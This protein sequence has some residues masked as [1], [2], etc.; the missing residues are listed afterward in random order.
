MNEAHVWLQ[1]V[2]TAFGSVPVYSIRLNC[3][4]AGWNYIPRHIF[5]I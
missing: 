5:D 3:R 1:Q 2:D 4:I